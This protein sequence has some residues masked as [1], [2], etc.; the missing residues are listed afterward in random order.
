MVSTAIK[1]E[2]TD[3]RGV[4]FLNDSSLVSINRSPDALNVW[5]NYSDMQGSCIETRPGYK[6][7][8]QIGTQINGIYVLSLSKAIVHSGTK[9]YE[10]NNFPLTPN[11][12]DLIELYSNMDKNTKTSFN[13]FGNNLYINDGSNYLLY[14]GTEVKK[15]SEE[16]FIPTTTIGRKPSGG[17][18]M[19]QDVNVLQ[20]KRVNS[21]LADGTSKDYV[22]DAIGIDLEEVTAI[23]NGETLKENT[24]FTVNRASGI[25]TFNIAP[26][27][28]S[29]AGT[30]NVFIT[31]AKT[32][33][34]YEDRIA[35]CTKSL[36][37][38]ERLFF[39]GNPMY[40]NAIFHC[41]LNNPSY[42]SDLAYYEDGASDSKIKDMVVGNNVLWVF[43]DLDQNNA[44]I[45]YHEQSFDEVQ[46]S[47]YPARQGNVSTGCYVRGINFKDDIVY[48]SKEGL[49]AI[50]TENLNS[51]Q[52]I[53]HR[54]SLVDSKMI[55]NTD[56]SN[57]YMAEW[58]GYLLILV[59]NKIFLADSR[60]KFSSLNSF[61]YE[62]FY[63][64][65]PHC[66]ANILKEYNGNLYIGAKDGSIFYVNGTNDNEETIESYWTTPMDNF[67][68]GN[69]LKT[70]NKRGGIAKIKTMPN[71]VVKVAK[72]T[73]KTNEYNYVT[74]KSSK[75]FD[76]NNIDFNN[77]TFTTS[78]QSYLV[79]KIKEKKVNE[80]SLKFYS[81][82]KDKPFGI[83]STI[84]ET[85]I[86]GYVKK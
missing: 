47:I 20:P 25:I 74:E 2:Y 59:G 1:R 64:D 39:T 12:E 33:I 62:W 22:L 34:G 48:L 17:G 42:I 73:D 14:D 63:W 71:G 32:V 72:R 28:P 43:K 75:G 69:Q 80:I 49:E 82:E 78:N 4:D 27:E 40:P 24:D 86:G 11:T 77:F 66:N 35:K 79:I 58:Q 10:W 52:V 29:L 3:F 21:F 5:K 18:E 83:Y 54:S 60:Q 57:S 37:F 23:V 26:S 55:N 61:E 38:D 6:K 19:F 30:D 50:A 84:F 46:G 36:I 8:A 56:Y 67:G 65:L 16:A 76:F 15:V 51:R 7:I 9:L 13:K 44:N 53:A 70:T 81:D 85:F 68:Y 31:F 45:F 41:K